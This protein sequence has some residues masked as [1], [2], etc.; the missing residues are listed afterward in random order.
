MSMTKHN[1]LATTLWALLTLTA[2]TACEHEM[3]IDYHQSEPRYVVEASL[4]EEMTQVHITSTRPMSGGNTEEYISDAQVVV[5]GD[6]GTRDTAIYANKGYYLAATRGIAGHTYKLEVNAGGQRFTSTSTMQRKPVMSQCRFVWK[7]I[8][9]LKMLFID[10]KIEDFANE[11]NYY[12]V[13]V[14]RNDYSY[15]WAVIRDNGN[16]DGDLQQLFSCCTDENLNKEGSSEA[17]TDVM[18][19]GDRIRLE[20]RA[21]DRRAYDYLASMERMSSTGTN[22]IDNFDGGCLG[23]FSAYSQLTR[24]LVFREKNIEEDE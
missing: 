11:T 6:D 5:T 7:K 4:T 24:Y 3:D 19:E 12:Y 2:T 22:P 23:Y 16:P 10:L 8:M 18:C 20:I 9:S 21:I 14:Y 13:H 15:R 17:D 1:I